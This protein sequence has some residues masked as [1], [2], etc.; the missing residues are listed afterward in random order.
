MY[1]IPGVGGAGVVLS[2]YIWLEG[3][4]AGEGGYD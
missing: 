2:I 3:V 4:E 1:F